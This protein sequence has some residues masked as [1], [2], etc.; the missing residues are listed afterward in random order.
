VAKKKK[1]DMEGPSGNEWLT[2]YSDMVTLVLCFF[3]IMFN[4]DEVQPSSLSQITASFM[5][6][7]MGS[8]AGG[9]TL[10]VGRYADLGNN[11]NSL[12][13]MDRGKSLGTA[14]RKAVSIFAPEVKSKKMTI[15][16]DERGIIISLASDAFFAPAS[17][18]INI[19]ATRDILLRLGQ[20]LASNDLA[21]SKFR[22]EGHTDS[23]P[24]DPAGP[25][26]SNWQLSAM[27]SINV[28]H[29][30]TDL[31][32][33]EKRFQVAGFADTMPVSNDNTP[34]GRAYNRRV[35]IVI[36]DEAHL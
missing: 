1:K 11:I 15:T 23:T 16:S 33:S 18:V 26:E 31:G 12:P 9:N 3:A 6:R 29:Y 14:M 5:L 27:R 2:T 25:W 21:G 17:A 28:L 35:D 32:I 22:I 36:L 24:I 7:G 30:L 34:E 4:P 20:L 19:E 10:A 8:S 13:A